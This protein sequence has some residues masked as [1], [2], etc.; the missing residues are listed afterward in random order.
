MSVQSITGAPTAT[1]RRRPARVGV[2][3][4]LEAAGCRQVDPDLFFGARRQDTGPR[5]EAAKEVC[6]HCPVREA[7]LRSALV[8]EERDGVWGGLTPAER[9]RFGRQLGD[10]ID[11]GEQASRRSDAEL[12]AIGREQRRARPGVVLLLTDR[13]WTQA[14]L[15]SALGVEPAAVR[16]ARI[17]AERI[18]A[19]CRAVGLRAPTW[20]RV[21]VP[22]G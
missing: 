13:G 6:R 4:G 3:P 14:Q 16:T 20:A 19:H 8:H 2:L 22:V 7:C 10:L 12:M 17:T 15:A 1:A 9:R 18:V 5:V 21:V 11:L